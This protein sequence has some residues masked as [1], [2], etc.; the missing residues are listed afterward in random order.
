MLN[1]LDSQSE[2]AWRRQLSPPIAQDDALMAQAIALAKNGIYTTRPNPCVGCVIA[3][4]GTIIGSGFHYQAGQPHAEVFAL[5]QAGDAAKDATAY[6]T[7]EPCSHIGR[8]P[9]CVAALIAANVARVVIASVDPNPQVNGG[10]IQALLAAGIGVTVG[11]LQAEAERLNAGFFKVMRTGLPFVRLKIAASLDGGTAMASGQS[12]WI[13]GAAA[14][15]DVQRLRAQSG[16]IITG[17]GTVL[18]DNPRLNVRGDGQTMDGVPLAD[19]PPPK[20]VII[21]RRARVHQSDDWAIFSNFEVMLWRGGIAD[22]LESLAVQNVRNVLVEAG[23]KLAAAFIENG[24][25]DEL[26]VYQAPKL[27]G[28]CAR[29]MVALDFARLEAVSTWRIVLYETVGDDLKLVLH[30]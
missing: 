4:G 18:A 20:I 26:I 16:A 9:P 10:G 25:V 30:K 3:K 12:K 7:L 19:I 1:N 28:M 11:V 21:D 6:V 23:A 8:T 14:R 5:R 13:T 27:L 17:S 24:F 29:P 22:L 2:D 15:F